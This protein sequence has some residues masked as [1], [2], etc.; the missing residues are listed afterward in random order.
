MKNKNIYVRV[1]KV[2]GTHVATIAELFWSLFRPSDTVNV[3]KKPE[4][5]EAIL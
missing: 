4:S 2:A 1:W 3:G 5:I